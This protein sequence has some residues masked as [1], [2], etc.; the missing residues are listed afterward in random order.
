MTHEIQVT[1]TVGEAALIVAGLHIEV[2]ETIVRS[3]YIGREWFAWLCATRASC[4]QS[5]RAAS[6]F[7]LSRD[8]RL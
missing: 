6:G 4:S 2:A 7:E 1:V 5:S 8:H 3:I